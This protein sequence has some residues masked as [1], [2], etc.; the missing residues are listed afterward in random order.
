M[1]PF[2]VLAFTGFKTINGALREVTLYENSI[3]FTDDPSTLTGIMAYFRRDFPVS[4]D[5]H[6]EPWRHV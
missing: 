6:S 1:R 2:V 4:I 5:L 3:T